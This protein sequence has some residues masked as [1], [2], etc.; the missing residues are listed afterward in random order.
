MKLPVS[1]YRL[2]F[3]KEF[4]FSDAEKILEYLTKLGINDIYASPVFSAVKGSMHGYDI[5][6]HRSLNPELG[7]DI[8]FSELQI[9]REKLGMG[10]IQDIVPNH[11]AFHF[12]NMMLRDLLENG[13]NSEFRDFFDIEWHHT[14]ESL[15]GRLLVPFL[16]SFYSDTLDRGEIKILYE[17]SGLFVMYYEH[18]FPL[19]LSSYSD[20][21]GYEELSASAGAGNAESWK[22]KL[23]GTLHQFSVISGLKNCV[24]NYDRIAHTKK[25]LRELYLDNHEARHYMDSRLSLF[26]ITEERG[27]ADRI[28]SILEKQMYRLSFWKVAA[29]EI[30]YRRFFNINSLISLRVEQKKVF[31]YIHSMLKE[32]IDT[33]VITGIRVDHVD[34]LSDPAKYL[35]WLQQLSVDMYIVVEKIINSDEQ[36]PSSWPVH[37]TTGYDYLN[38]VNSIFC[39]KENEMEFS[40]I[41]SRFTDL[42]F[43]FDEF[44]AEKKRLIIEK[45]MTGDIDNLAHL[46]KNFSGKDRYGRDITMASLRNALVEIIAFFP[47][48]RTY[49][50]SVEIS[51]TDREYIVAALNKARK[52]KPE[53]LFEYD[54][55]EKCLTLKYA[56]KMDSDKTGRLL[57]FITR[58]QQYTAPFMAK[59]F[60][61]TVLYIIN[62]LIS[63]NEV[64]GDPKVFGITL[65]DFHKYIARRFDTHRYSMNAT[66]THDTK[67]GEDVRCRINVLS[68]IP[69]EWKNSLSSWS[70]LNN[71]KKK[72]IYGVP[73]PDRNDEYFIY[74]TLIGTFPESFEGYDEYIKRIRDYMIKSVREAK[75]H[76]AWIKPDIEYEEK[77][78]HFIDRILTP[79]DKNIFLKK[80]GSFSRWISFYGMLNSLSQVIIKIASPGV[81]DFYQGTE[82]WDLHLVDPD[83]RG[84]VDYSLRQDYI[85]YIEEMEMRDLPGLIRELWDTRSDGRIKLFLIHRLLHA[86]NRMSKLFAD[87]EYI[88]LE[89]TGRFSD[90]VIAFLRIYGNQASIAI[91]ARLLTSMVSEGVLPAGELW[92]DTAVHLPQGFTAEVRDAITGSEIQIQGGLSLSKTMILFPGMLLTGRI[93]REL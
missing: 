50:N 70:R 18:K 54:F 4:R 21:F 56:E 58:F 11:M 69:G 44:I 65:I 64:G 16:G 35:E 75:V 62:R 31:D 72:K 9:N 47:V 46:L 61:D 23:Y 86:R 45:H 17:E 14:H 13:E 84:I 79:S 25:M 37:G 10:W 39:K 59:G 85:Q 83:N 81:P 89:T 5:V 12:E 20:I 73:V 77:L 7:T 33:E 48:Y 78:L 43:D 27:D 24:G 53:Y 74:Q 80:L 22:I 63:L 55:L 26:S 8:D 91:A 36:L 68:E 93:I 34:G 2:Q 15:R 57:K 38:H 42:H 40:R 51:R 30:N 41:Y 3:N 60:E 1:T 29:E 28:D 66:S 67:R 32:L 92:S 88:P 76:T 71:A 90:S 82:L 49:I 6:D 52:Y 87:G 19:S